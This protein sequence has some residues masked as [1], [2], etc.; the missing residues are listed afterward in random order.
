VAA[1][2]WVNSGD[3]G[4]FDCY[5]LVSRLTGEVLRFGEGCDEDPPEDI[6]DVDLYV[7]VPHKREFDLG[8]S[9]A[10]RFT[11]QNL[12]GSYETVRH[13]FDSRGAFTRFKALLQRAGQ[14][15]AWHR[16]QEQAVEQALQ[17][18]CEQQGFVVERPRPDTG[19]SYQ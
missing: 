17:E 13:Y 6:E 5:A 9:L 16:Y 18:W 3:D 7:A 14:L 2:D 11:E 10:L 12:A 4:A 8:R 19:R 15:E 1:F